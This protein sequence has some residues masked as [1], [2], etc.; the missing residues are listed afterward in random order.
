MLAVASL[1]SGCAG[2]GECIASECQSTATL[3]TSRAVGGAVTNVEICV[4]HAGAPVQQCATAVASASGA[5]LVGDLE[6]RVTTTESAVEVTVQVDLPLVQTSNEYVEDDLWVVT[7][8]APDGAPLAEVGY[9]A[10][11][12]VNDNCPTECRSASFTERP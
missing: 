10:A 11:Y 4:F 3:I 5:P 9:D 2:D 8:Q 1:A 7:F 12:I 6:G